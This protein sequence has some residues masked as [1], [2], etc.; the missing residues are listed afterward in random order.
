[1][2]SPPVDSFKRHPVTGTFSLVRVPYLRAGSGPCSGAAY[3]I[4][5]IT[6]TCPRL[7]VNPLL[8]HKGNA[9]I[10]I[11]V[12]PVRPLPC[13]WTCWVCYINRAPPIRTTNTLVS[14]THEPPTSTTPL[15]LLG[16]MSSYG[17]TFHDIN[18]R[19]RE[20]L[21]AITEEHAEIKMDRFP[22]DRIPGNYEIEIL[23]SPDGRSSD[24]APGS[25]T[26]TL[27]HLFYDA[28]L[29]A[30]RPGDLDEIH[31][32]N[33]HKGIRI[34]VFLS[35]TPTAPHPPTKL[36]EVSDHPPP[37]NL[38]WL[39]NFWSVRSRVSNR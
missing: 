34:T 35:L 33:S 7:Y 25:R 21:E 19:V 20:G 22:V 4:T 23:T 12:Q 29:T 6:R 36:V 8:S 18:K 37:S 17:S 32:S 5:L 1:M 24:P 27:I 9:V 13:P 26:G 3:Y 16:I 31:I 28:L 2:A 14:S 15:S 11:P 10:I 39:V 38:Q 30:T